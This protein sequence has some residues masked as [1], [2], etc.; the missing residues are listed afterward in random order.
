MMTTPKAVIFDLGKVLLDFDYG[1][2]IDRL[3]KRC[4]LSTAE[5]QT[6]LNQSPLLHQYETNLL[7]TAQFFAEVQSASGFCG[8]LEEFRDLF[9]D[10]FTAIEPMIQ[11]HGE[12]RSQ[13]TPTYIFSNTNE[14]AVCH[15][16]RRFP[17][18]HHFD[19]YI[20]SYEH[21][22]MKP[23]SRLYEVV[24]HAAQLSGA[25]LL[26]ID[27]RLEN[28]EAGQRRG[29]RTILHQSSETTRLAVQ[30]AGLV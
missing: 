14:I 4:R 1:I 22:V 7:T 12:L 25:D 24:E 3:Q 2:A 9:S 30:K 13:G 18:F 11:L 29:W 19:G 15:I 28:I 21:N 20:L 10:I 27:D 17:F 26:Y 23:D 8:N 16:R 6:L 5:L